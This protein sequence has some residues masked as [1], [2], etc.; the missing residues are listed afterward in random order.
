MDAYTESLLEVANHLLGDDY[1]ITDSVG[2]Q[3]AARIIVK[4]IKAIYPG[5]NE[6]PVDAWRRKHRKCLFCEHCRPLAPAGVSII[7]CSDYKWCDAKKKSVH[8]D[9]PRPWCRIFKLKKENE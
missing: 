1:Y 3:E 6:D 9:M 8:F 4:D 2:G 5:R 7:G